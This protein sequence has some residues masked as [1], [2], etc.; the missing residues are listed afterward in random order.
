FD[1]YSAAIQPYAPMPVTGLT[2]RDTIVNGKVAVLVSWKYS[3]ETTFGFPLPFGFSFQMQKHD[4]S[5]S[6]EAGNVLHYL[7]TLP[8]SK[9][10]YTVIVHSG[11][12]QSIPDS[13]SHSPNLRVAEEAENSSIRLS[14]NP[15]M[16]GKDE[17]LTV[18]CNSDCSATL[19]FYDALGR[20]IAP[21]VRDPEIASHHEFHF[22]L[23]DAGVRF[24]RLEEVFDSEVRVITGKI[25]V[26]GH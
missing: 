19:T 2:A 8:L 18:D 12:F 1:I 9:S 11:R 4:T 14:E 25:I 21:E 16:V 22:T 5:I 17:R 24:Y 10:E 7:D 20:E 13:V 3:D 26:A 6:T 23:P 15:A